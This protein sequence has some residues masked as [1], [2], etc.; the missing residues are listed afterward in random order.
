MKISKVISEN[1]KTGRYQPEKR[2]GSPNRGILNLERNESNSEVECLAA[3]V[4]LSRCLSDFYVDDE[5]AFLVEAT[6]CLAV[7]VHQ[8]HWRGLRFLWSRSRL[9]R[10]MS[11][12]LSCF[13]VV[14]S[15]PSHEQACVASRHSL[16]LADSSDTSKLLPSRLSSSSW[17]IPS[18]S[19]ASPLLD[20]QI[21][22]C[23]FK[24]IPIFSIVSGTFSK[25]EGD[26]WLR[27]SEWHKEASRRGN[28][29]ELSSSQD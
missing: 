9:T 26:F 20:N 18:S 7:H 1:G 5:T 2:G 22:Q 14:E 16:L 21:N 6:K 29:D 24:V 28:A 19:M 17:S 4:C 13:S 3:S 11:S 8:Q 10:S 12:L 15:H 27:R 23:K 25:E